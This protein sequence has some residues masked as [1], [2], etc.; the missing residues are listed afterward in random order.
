M[1]LGLS[2]PQTL[3]GPVGSQFGLDEAGRRYMPPLVDPDEEE[4][5]FDDEEFDPDMEGELEDELEDGELDGEFDDFDAE[6]NPDMAFPPED[7]DEEMG[8]LDMG[9][10]MGGIDMAAALDG[11]MGDEMMGPDMGDDELEIPRGAVDGEMGDE[12]GDM[13]GDEMMGPEMGDELGDMM[14][15]EMG[16]ELGGEGDF[17]I[18]DIVS[19]EDAE[20]LG[21]EFEGEE[22]EYDGELGDEEDF[23]DIDADDLD[24][25]GMKTYMRHMAKAHKSYLNKYMH[26]ESL[27]YMPTSQAAKRSSTARL[28]ERSHKSQE[29]Q[30]NENPAALMSAVGPM[31]KQ[32]GQWA[33]KNPQAVGQAANAAGSAVGG[34][35]QG[36]QNQQPQMMKRHM[37]KDGKSYMGKKHMKHGMSYMKKEGLETEQEFLDTLSSQARGEVAQQGKFYSGLAEDALYAVDD[38]NQGLADQQPPQPQAGDVGFA[39]QGRVGPN[40]GSGYEMS[41]FDDIPYVGES[42]QYDDNQLIVE[43]SYMQGD[44]KK[45]GPEADAMRR[46]DTRPMEPHK[47]MALKDRGKRMKHMVKESG[48]TDG[49][50]PQMADQWLDMLDMMEAPRTL[51]EISSTHA[52][53]PKAHGPVKLPKE[54]MQQLTDEAE[55]DKSRRRAKG[56]EGKDDPMSLDPHRMKQLK[57]KAMKEHHDF[58]GSLVSSAKRTRTGW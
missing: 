29:K 48:M 37:A 12:L 4:E 52:D 35:Q 36:M 58:L 19:D 53:A 17:D 28:L 13:M 50:E 31:A 20:L 42:S 57:G 30:L 49:M 51:D 39:P 1:S 45:E 33:M 54:R 46:A 21:P 25:E 27:K 22:D 6:G 32:A 44:S 14:G 16:D 5:E 55:A 18:D 43:G 9:D 47:A 10:D 11:E 15:P 26:A 7:P 23:D 41:D 38:P 8:G 56:L 2:N 34:F 3:G 40:V 24:A